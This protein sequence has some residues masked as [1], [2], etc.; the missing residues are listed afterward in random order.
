ML[1]CCHRSS[2]LVLNRLGKLDDINNGEKLDQ[3]GCWREIIMY[4]KRNRNRDEQSVNICML[5]MVGSCGRMLFS[6]PVPAA[7]KLRRPEV[8]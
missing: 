6:L 4:S 8:A 7:E 5:L 2:F 3:N 1:G